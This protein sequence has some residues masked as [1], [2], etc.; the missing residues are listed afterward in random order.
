MYIDDTIDIIECVINM[1]NHVFH[2]MYMHLENT[3]QTSFQRCE[4]I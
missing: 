2:F 1:M 4:K 3:N